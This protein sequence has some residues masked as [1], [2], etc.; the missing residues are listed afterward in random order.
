MQFETIFPFLDGNGRIGQLLIA[1][2]LE[3]WNLLDQSLLYLSL[4]LKRNQEE[5]YARL[6]AVRGI[7]ALTS[8]QK[9]NTLTSHGRLPP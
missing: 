7:G 4:A 3:H 9:W 6:D 2:L 5:Y 1:L 8:T